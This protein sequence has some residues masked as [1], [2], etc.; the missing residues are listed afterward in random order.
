MKL[1]P[2]DFARQAGVSRQA[3]AAKI[4]N[5]T[6]AVDPA[7]FL[8]TENPV[9]SAYI[10]DQGRRPH[11][12]ASTAAPAG[13][14]ASPPSLAAPAPQV[15]LG[16]EQISALAGVPAELLGLSL[17]ELVIRYNGMINLEKQARVLRDLTL[18]HEKELRTAERSIQLIEKD[19][20]TSRIF[21]YIDVLM[22]QIME[23]PESV[24]DAFIAKVLSEGADCR[25]E[26]V[27]MMRDGLGKIIAGAKD[28]V[29]KE[30]NGLKGKYNGNDRID[31]ISETIR[32]AV[33]ND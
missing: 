29:I 14:W 6:L 5:N 20:G 15:P 9:N 10:S 33:G 4:K 25:G 18:T 21:S 27:S 28:Q 30:L 19:F 24:M 8:D 13:A 16:D 32:E 11:Q 22:R 23:Y 31:E 1:K 12:A 7:G 17:R 2:A 3:V 26:L